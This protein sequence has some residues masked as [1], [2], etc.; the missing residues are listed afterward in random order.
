MSSSSSSIELFDPGHC[1]LRFVCLA[2][3][4]PAVEP[5]LGPSTFMSTIVHPHGLWGVSQKKKKSFPLLHVLNFNFKVQ[6]LYFIA[7]LEAFY[8]YSNFGLQTL[9]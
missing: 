2:P 9:E 5:Y 1:S 8:F 4:R 7:F 3:V 6:L